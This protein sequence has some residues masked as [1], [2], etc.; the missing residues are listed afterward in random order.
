MCV[1]VCLCVCVCTCGMSQA[2]IP[3]VPGGIDEKQGIKQQIATLGTHLESLA[4]LQLEREAVEIARLQR[5]LKMQVQI[6]G[7]NISNIPMYVCIYV[8]TY[9]RTYIRM[10]VYMYV[11]MYV[12]VYMSVNIYETT[13]T[14][15]TYQ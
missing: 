6:D 12:C 3:T 14:V 8:C 11:C 13:S 1:Y 7:F 10:Y 9:G 2:I 4:K 5:E 15:Y